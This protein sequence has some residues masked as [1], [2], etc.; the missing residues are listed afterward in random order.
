MIGG[1]RQIIILDNKSPEQT[2]K[3]SYKHIEFSGVKGIGR[4][5]FPP[6]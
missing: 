6:V 1:N 2:L 5:G 4:P 3:G